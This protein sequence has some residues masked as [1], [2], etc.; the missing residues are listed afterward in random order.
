[1]GS[2]DDH[3]GR[4]EEEF[5]EKDGKFRPLPLSKFSSGQPKTKELTFKMK[6]ES[7]I[8]KLYHAPV[9]DKFVNETLNGFRA[10]S[11]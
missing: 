8:V 5:L 10:S 7:L 2:S 6:N 4:R 9:R 1:M 11:T 3:F